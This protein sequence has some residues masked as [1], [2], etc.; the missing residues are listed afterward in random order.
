MKRIAAIALALCLAFG[1]CVNAFAIEKN[2]D[3]GTKDVEIGETVTVTIDL[4]G[5][6]TGVKLIEARIY[7]D[8]IF[9]EFPEGKSGGYGVV[10]GQTAQADGDMDYATLNYV[11]ATSDGQTFEKGSLYTLTFKARHPMTKEQAQNIDFKLEIVNLI[12][13]ERQ[14]DKDENNNGENTGKPGAVIGGSTVKPSDEANP[15]TGAPAPFAAAAAVL[16]V[17]SAKEFLQGGKRK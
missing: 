15:S 2:T 10:L 1:L 4:K 9:F 6:L 16:A 12:A 8:P 13:D 7:Y 17:I 5:K 14:A 3:F 11:D